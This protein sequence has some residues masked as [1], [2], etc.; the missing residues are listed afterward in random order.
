MPGTALTP[1]FYG[2]IPAVGDFVQR[3]LPA[4][5]VTA[6]DLW[7]ATSLAQGRDR[8]G[9][10]AWRRAY[11]T[12]PLWRFILAPGLCGSAAAAGVMAPSVDR[13]GRCFPVV[14]AL[15]GPTLPL[16]VLLS[17]VGTAWF[18][19][20]E[21]VAFDTLEQRLAADEVA[22]RLAALAP[23]PEAAAQPAPIRL[24]AVATDTPDMDAQWPSLP[25]GVFADAGL[26]ALAGISLWWTSGSDLVAPSR[27]LCPGLPSPSRAGAMLDG[28][29]SGFGWNEPGQTETD[30]HPLA[31]DA[32]SGESH[33]DSGA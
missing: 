6:W 9:E 2:K 17:P 14:L 26:S 1:G 16:A 23:L 33:A 28:D 13:V 25:L 7:L 19:A 4:A 31:N 24:A 30:A 22:R 3:G 15:T 5:F 11:M 27:L 18:M 20:M 8:L 29:W 21:D 10:D 32:T 12:A